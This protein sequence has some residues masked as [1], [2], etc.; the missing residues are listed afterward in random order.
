LVNE[1]SIMAADGYPLAA[2]LYEP[3]ASSGRMVLV[4]SAMAVK[5]MY[6]HRFASFLAANGFTV[7]TYD[8]RGI[9]G[10]RPQNLRGFDAALWE[11]GEKDQGAMIVWLMEGYP[12]H[13]L[14][15]V[16]H[17]V[18]GQIIGLTE[19]NRHFIGFLGVAPQSGYWRLWPTLWLRLRMLILW[20][21]VIPSTVGLAGY[22]PGSRFGLGEDLPA[23]VALEWARAGRNTGYLLGLHGESAHDHYDQFTAAMRVYSIEDDTYAPRPTV[24]KLLGFYPHA[25]T[26]HLHI[27]PGD[28]GV[29]TIGHFGFFR[30]KF[31]PTL[32]HESANWLL[33]Q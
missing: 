32:W 31:E 10:S 27:R 9:G 8:Y 16:G 26:E 14:L 13:T 33:D 29:K 22:F 7:L 6:Y 5:R 11:W 23:G 2:T 20:Y 1:I 4:N 15:G 12:T 18:G 25:H 30:E 28:L 19:H 3:Q 17:S 24:E 21:A